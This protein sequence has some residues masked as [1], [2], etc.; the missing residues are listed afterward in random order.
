MN[1]VGL[2]SI[3][4]VILLV[5]A[6]V[7]ADFATGAPPA[8]LA[9]EPATL[10]ASAPFAGG[11]SVAPEIASSGQ[12][13]TVRGPAGATVLVDGPATLALTI[14][15]TGSLSFLPPAPGSYTLTLPTN[16]A[17]AKLLVTSPG[18]L[19]FADALAPSALLLPNGDVL[20]HLRIPSDA[21]PAAPPVVV[22]SRGDRIPLLASQ[23]ESGMSYASLVD[24]SRGVPLAI[25]GIP[26]QLSAPLSLSAVAPE[27]PVADAPAL[28]GSL[29]PG[30]TPSAS[31][32]I[33]GLLEALD[34]RAA[35]ESSLVGEDGE[36]LGLPA[37]ARLVTFGKR[38]YWVPAHGASDRLDVSLFQLDEIERLQELG[39]AERGTLPV[40]ITVKEPSAL[41]PLPLD[42]G[43][44]AGLAGSVSAV[45]PVP[46]PAL[47]EAL[48][49]AAQ[50]EALGLEARPLPL[51]R[52][53]ATTVPMDALPLLSMMPRVERV[54]LD[55]LV[56]KRLDD[57]V[58]AALG[59]NR[60][61]F[62]SEF[63]LAG[64][65]MRIAVL[66][67]GI[68]ASHP[69]L[70][71]QDDNAATTDPKVAAW[72][73]FTGEPCA[74]P[75]DADG[76]GT[77]V[78]G[79]A[80]GTAAGSPYAGVAPQASLVVGKVLS[81]EGYGLDS[82]IIG[83]IQW[84]LDPDANPATPDGAHV[85][86]MSLGGYDASGGLDPVERA[87][88]AATD[89][90]V[91]VVVAAGN[92]GPEYGT[93]G[94][95][96]TAP[97]ALTVGAYSHATGSVAQFS[98]RGPTLG[99]LAKPELVAPGVAITAPAAGSN[100][101]VTYS[102]TSMATPH[103]SGAAAL[104]RE[105]RPLAT[106]GEIKGTLAAAADARPGDALETGIGSLNLTRALR[107]CILVSDGVGTLR[108]PGTAT[109]TLRNRCESS[110]NLAPVL[111]LSPNMTA[112]H[113]AP[114]TLAAFAAANVTVNVTSFA[115]PINVAALEFGAG[116]VSLRIQVVALSTTI[117]RLDGPLASALAV[118]D[119]QGNLA[120]LFYYPSGDI[121]LPAIPAGE[122]WRVVAASFDNP[123]VGLVMRDVSGASEITL[124]TSV[125]ADPSRH[126]GF[127]PRVVPLA[128]A[129]S[130]Q[131]FT[132][133]RCSALR[134]DGPA[135]NFSFVSV[136][137]SSS[138]NLVVDTGVASWPASPIADPVAPAQALRVDASDDLGARVRL[139]DA[140]VRIPAVRYGLVL[141]LLMPDGGAE[142]NMSVAPVGGPLATVELRAWDPLSERLGPYWAS[143][144]GIRAGAS[145][146]NLP[147]W[148]DSVRFVPTS[149]FPFF[150]VNMSGVFVT[151][152]GFLGFGGPD[153]GCCQ[154]QAIPSTYSPNGVIAGYWTDLDPSRGGAV[155]VG[156]AQVFGANA[157]LF[158]YRGVPHYGGSGLATSFEM[159]LLPNGQIFISILDAPTDG[160]I[161]TVGV[162]NMLGTEA[163]RISYG[164]SDLSRVA[165]V[166]TPR[167]DSSAPMNG[168]CET[169][170]VHY[171]CTSV[172]FAWF[173]VA[174]AGDIL[175]DP[176]V[177]LGAGPVLPY[178]RMQGGLVTPFEGAG[179]AR[180][181]FSGP[182]GGESLDVYETAYSSVNGSYDVWFSNLPVRG[183]VTTSGSLSL[184]P[185]DGRTPAL[186]TLAGDLF[187][188]QPSLVRATVQPAGASPVQLSIRYLDDES[189]LHQTVIPLSSTTDSGE[190]VLPAFRGD[191][192]IIEAASADGSSQRIRLDR[193][194]DAGLSLTLDRSA[195]ADCRP[196][197][198]T[199]ANEAPYSR[200]FVL[201]TGAISWSIGVF[202]GH[203]IDFG[204]IGPGESATRPVWLELPPQQGPWV[205]VA[206]AYTGSG[207]G[208]F[209]IDSFVVDRVV[210]VP[211]VTTAAGIAT[212]H[213]GPGC[214]T[215]AA[216]SHDNATA[217]LVVVA[218]CADMT[219]ARPLVGRALVQ[220]VAHSQQFITVSAPLV[221]DVPAGEAMAVAD[222]A[223]RAADLD[224]DG[225]LGALAV[226][227]R[228]TGPGAASADFACASFVAHRSATAW[229]S[230]GPVHSGA[231]TLAATDMIVDGD[232]DVGGVVYANGAPLAVF[233]LLDAAA[234]PACC[235]RGFR[236]TASFAPVDTDGD[237]FAGWTN[238]TIA[239]DGAIPARAQGFM[240]AYSPASDSSDATS[241][242][243]FHG[244]N[245][246][247]A[248]VAK[249]VDQA[250]VWSALLI[251]GVFFVQGPDR[252]PDLAVEPI[253]RAYAPR[254]T[255]PSLR[256]DG[257]VE[258]TGES[259]RVEGEL[260]AWGPL[261][262]TV[263]GFNL[264]GS[265]HS[266]ARPLTGGE[267]DSLLGRRSSGAVRYVSDLRACGPA[268]TDFRCV[269]FAHAQGVG[270]SATP[271]HVRA[272]VLGAAFVDSDGDTV[273]DSLSLRGEVRSDRAFSGSWCALTNNAVVACGEATS[274]GAAPV[275]VGGKFPLSSPLPAANDELRILVNT[276]GYDG[277]G[278]AV[279]S[280][281]F[282]LEVPAA[283]QP[284]LSIGGIVVVPRDFDGDGVT[285]AA[286]ASLELTLRAPLQGV[287]V[288]DVR[289]ED[290]V[291]NG[292]YWSTFA[293]K[294]AELPVGNSTQRVVAFSNGAVSTPVRLVA[295]ASVYV[296]S[297]SA[298]APSAHGRAEA[299][300]LS[301]ERYLTTTARVEG[302]DGYGAASAAPTMGRVSLVPSA[303][304]DRSYLFCPYFLPAGG[305]YI[306]YE[307]SD[308][309]GSL[310][311]PAEWWLRGGGD[312]MLFAYSC[313][314]GSCAYTY[315][316]H[317]T[318]L[319]DARPL[320]AATGAWGTAAIDLDG[321]GDADA[322]Q[323]SPAYS[324][325]GNLLVSAC[326]GASQ[327]SYSHPNMACEPLHAANERGWDHVGPRLLLGGISGN[328]TIDGAVRV[329]STQACNAGTYVETSSERVFMGLS[330]EALAMQVL[331]VMPGDLDGDGTADAA[332][333][334]LSVRL[335]PGYASARIF[336]VGASA[337]L[338]PEHP[339][340]RIQQLVVNNSGGVGV[341]LC[342][343]A[344]DDSD[345]FARFDCAYR[346]VNAVLEPLF[347]M[348]LE[349]VHVDADSDG[350]VDA[351]D[352]AFP[353]ELSSSLSYAEVNAYAQYGDV[354]YASAW[355]PITPGEPLT[356]RMPFSG[357]SGPTG[358]YGGAGLYGCLA[359]SP[360]VC[361]FAFAYLASAPISSIEPGIALDIRV[362]QA[363][364]DGDGYFDRLLANATWS[365]PHGGAPVY[366]CLEVCFWD[367]ELANAT[368]IEAEQT[369]GSRTFRYPYLVRQ[370]V[371]MQWRTPSNVSVYLWDSASTFVSPDL[372]DAA[373]PARVAGTRLQDADFSG[374]NETLLVDV[375]VDRDTSLWAWLHPTA[376]EPCGWSASALEGSELGSESR[377]TLRLPLDAVAG[378]GA[379]EAFV[380]IHSYGPASSARVVPGNLTKQGYS[381]SEYLRMGVELPGA[382]E[383]TL[384][385][386]S[387]S[388]ST[389]YGWID[390]T[391][392]YTA[393]GLDRTYLAASL[394]RPDFQLQAFNSSNAST[395][396][397]RIAGP[398]LRGASLDVSGMMV[399]N[400]SLGWAYAGSTIMPNA[401]PSGPTG[402]T[403]VVSYAGGNITLGIE[404]PSPQPLRHLRSHA[405]VDLHRFEKGVRGCAADEQPTAGGRIAATFAGAEARPLVGD[406][407]STL[408]AAV[409]G[410]ADFASLHGYGYG[411]S[412]GTDVP[413]TLDGSRLSLPAHADPAEPDSL[414]MPAML[415]ATATR[416]FHG[417]DD[418][419]WFRAPTAGTFVACPDSPALALVLLRGSNET[420]G[421]G[422]VS[423]SVAANETVGIR[424]ADPWRYGPEATYRVALAVEGSAPDLAV[425][426]GSI[427]V[428]GSPAT[429]RLVHVSAVV[430]NQ[431]EGTAENATLRL[432]A[433]GVPVATVLTGPLAPGA[434]ATRTLEW[435]PT[436]GGD[437]DLTVEVLSVTPPEQMG[438]ES[439][440]MA[441]ARVFVAAR[442][443][444]VTPDGASTAII[445]PGGNVTYRA[446]VRNVG[447][448][449]DTYSL[450][451]SAPPTGWSYSLSA[452][453][454]SL[455]PNGTAI[456]D[457]TV[458]ADSATSGAAVLTLRAASTEQHERNATATFTTT[459]SA[460]GAVVAVTNTDVRPGGNGTAHV[461]IS[462]VTQ[463]GTVTFEIN[464]NAS[465]AQVVAVNNG[466]VSGSSIAHNINN[467]IGRVRILVT[468]S[469]VPG[470]S[471]DLLLASIV[472]HA[473][474][475]NGAQ[476]PLDLEVIELAHSD[477]SAVAHL[478]QDGLLRVRGLLGDVNGDGRVTGVD[479]LFIS[480]YVVG[481]RQPTDLILDNADVNRDGRVSGVD[482]LFISQHVVGNRPEL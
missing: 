430:R 68:N 217:G 248:L 138:S 40:I 12:P 291:H 49:L 213:Q 353:G 110:V 140:I 371:H 382:I 249:A 362:A 126:V 405:C 273:A 422:C 215:L 433:N 132:I 458:R 180:G 423:A 84:A 214:A 30:E 411:S 25:E 482:A 333:V 24:A 449:G 454:V 168:T 329:C 431:G 443:V 70:D 451:T 475:G 81:D 191:A 106:P 2:S 299:T 14:P 122:T 59:A 360:G 148:D 268:A 163:V 352:V 429:G 74:M 440:N 401:V 312:V 355:R 139:V 103:V 398:A 157:A 344:G 111:T 44:V 75:C 104:F 176:V 95:P 108:A 241:T 385:V 460:Q 282:P 239:F 154:G 193:P 286:E 101:Y 188:A 277:P 131:H 258:S 417:Y 391:V 358:L 92:S 158:Q 321:D 233:N 107:S 421:V 284:A 73:V 220:S 438:N 190:A 481:N 367:G 234:S 194:Y 155:L 293:F 436:T 393:R 208:A 477:G 211:G 410:S 387:V 261:G 279:M 10:G 301:T 444:Q 89:A 359:E 324:A 479:A 364:L 270:E 275:S 82:W 149:P 125:L 134:Y 48:A 295:T 150:G 199:V 39:F 288:L 389:S 269:A 243:R 368:G 9:D 197:I 159:A 152:N 121:V 78:A 462:N 463:F 34:L 76:H 135:S 394:Y 297:G 375:D 400:G 127:R 419:D 366:A 166:L 370:E 257:Y 3:C 195:G 336:G 335:T 203:T 31:R 153:H 350:Q 63:G 311:I 162:E 229:V 117:I 116:P 97:S 416:N 226:D 225:I 432:L 264:S 47:D 64:A 72:R 309:P 137:A 1:R 383:A 278:Q 183:G 259:S 448:V 453:N 325:D 6:G 468:T 7:P 280:S 340:A 53:V 409:F 187:A 19:S 342:Y 5:A 399:A 164:V 471:G 442:G 118:L 345:W 21:V 8:P 308:A 185:V 22:T 182:H 60:T 386:T 224:G 384:N 161:H 79:T 212:V 41:P 86:S 100:G 256:L 304:I 337:M 457:V 452:S 357:P 179:I 38:A 388:S 372:W 374:A 427:A 390:A 202:Q 143:P 109:F 171:A 313:N 170:S 172:E 209:A 263:I 219:L 334:N 262:G 160:N 425:V 274:T 80:A 408:L 480:Q 327:W 196:C 98:S 318:S 238:A 381:R 65:G 434:N 62:G 56:E 192:I 18:G 15:S 445:P 165:Y 292:T 356:I 412:W 16:G 459:L 156:P 23:G 296:N 51:V 235:E 186:A 141:G 69:A 472:F 418:V 181:A 28:L 461:R 144:E 272:S 306:G 175:V 52:A 407:N 147:L 298:W 447:N 142:V 253:A 35:G 13:V 128:S 251:D 435:T 205:A 221:V 4:F 223:A 392:N 204:H 112:T 378:C 236:H 54:H 17:Q 376:T 129:C 397:L 294:P 339:E 464:Y 302:R 276:W 207:Y 184:T 33:D 478:A 201:E 11:I 414:A 240:F 245:M 88:E 317:T 136:G 348:T 200:S 439:N 133:F 77:H 347:P 415:G 466:N 105:A 246:S 218:T 404:V 255:A 254:L 287:L 29:L 120:A 343:R 314:D 349:A 271:V 420:V 130:T 474:A 169:G 252:A 36:R 189:T 455:P 227:G 66:D 303:G 113:D 365:S 470:P 250:D 216:V 146:N 354:G 210:P 114:A 94:N 91:L 267:L 373:S 332:L 307:C 424:S 441:T 167:N 402:F 331:D 315:E 151:S 178:L 260:F 283:L 265:Q 37:D 177:R 322:V 45:A 363:D 26:G 237:G 351:I 403:P 58:A 465:V 102:G 231:F 71:D 244:R 85:V 174:T 300:V 310:D 115:H 222:L 285:D 145:G 316:T 90:G 319:P 266:L 428:S 289:A 446:L 228:V 242:V 396:E 32:P 290:P 323:A 320:L 341:S 305:V 346:P 247:A 281:G 123:L 43:P 93:I 57:S 87:V 437:V 413:V 46:A 369:F 330:R 467:T 50:L 27:L 232:L 380:S 61:A 473:V 198:A 83:G 469:E 379:A 395:G 338:T 326:V 377:G 206:Y 124:D 20:V 450:G 99:G 456:V 42:L 96:G 328:A 55:G 426:P 361:F 173:E 119:G 406:R 476:T 67:T 230:C